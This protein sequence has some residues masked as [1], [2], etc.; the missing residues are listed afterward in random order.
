MTWLKIALLTIG[1]GGM[2]ATYIYW[3]TILFKAYAADDK[4]YTITFDIDHYS[5]AKIEVFLYIM[6]SVAVLYSLYTIIA[7][8]SVFIG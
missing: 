6:L 5:E 2:L 1:I 7:N 4:K 3:G 8:L